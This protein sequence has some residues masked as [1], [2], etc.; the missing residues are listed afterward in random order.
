MYKKEEAKKNIKNKIMKSIVKKVNKLIEKDYPQKYKN[1]RNKI[2]TSNSTLI[3][4]KVTKKDD[5]LLW[6][7]RVRRILTYGKTRKTKNNLQLKNDQNFKD[8]LN[9][10]NNN[11]LS[12]N[13]RKIKYLLNLRFFHL[14]KIF[15]KSK[16]FKVFKESNKM[17]KCREEILKEKKHIDIFT[18]KGIMD[19]FRPIEDKKAKILSGA[20]LK[21]HHIHHFLKTS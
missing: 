16:D 7:M 20:I 10:K 8:I 21:C 14:I 6:K 17:I 13:F 19:L 18:E 5:R 3:T 4:S 1:G 11:G 12:D 15:T 9:D 2:H